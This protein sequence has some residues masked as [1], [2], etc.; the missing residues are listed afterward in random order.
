MQVA[1]SKEDNREDGILASD[2][3]LKEVG[4]RRSKSLAVLS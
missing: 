1:T 2:K 3:K 4:S